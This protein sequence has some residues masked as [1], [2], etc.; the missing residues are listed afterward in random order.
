[1]M[2]SPI[3]SEETKPNTKHVRAVL[4]EAAPTPECTSDGAHLWID[5]L[6]GILYVRKQDG[7]W[8][9]QGGIE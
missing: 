5:T 9:Q 7:T 3:M 2:T 6:T 4:S 8:T 1:M